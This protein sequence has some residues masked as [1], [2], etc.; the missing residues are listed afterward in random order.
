MPPAE[1]PTPVNVKVFVP[2]LVTVTVCTAEVEP[3]CWAAKVR[4][5]GEID[6]KP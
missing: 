4:L 2:V 6:A 5:D 1:T 3:F